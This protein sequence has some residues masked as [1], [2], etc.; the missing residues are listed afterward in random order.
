MQGRPQL[1]IELYEAAFRLSEGELYPARRNIVSAL[2]D[3]NRLDEA[4]RITESLTDDFPESGWSWNLNGVVLARMARWPE[5][6]RSFRRVLRLTP[7]DRQAE[8]MLL[9]SRT[10]W[11]GC[12]A[13]LIRPECSSAGTTNRWPS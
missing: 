12:F 11:A 8:I 1:A 13:T 4:L 3:L 5:A 2:I 9:A 7:D 10:R 6:E